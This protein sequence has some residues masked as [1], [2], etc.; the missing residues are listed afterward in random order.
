MECP[1][2]FPVTLDEIIATEYPYT[3]MD[4]AGEGAVCV[5]ARINKDE[6]GW[7]FHSIAWS[8]PAISSTRFDCSARRRQSVEIPEGCHS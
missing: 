5:R 4:C 8:N 6:I 7:G 2:S 1:S 3:L